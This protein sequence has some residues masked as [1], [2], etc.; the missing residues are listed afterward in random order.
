MNHIKLFEQ[1]INQSEFPA[2]GYDL[3]IKAKNILLKEVD[4]DWLDTN[5]IIKM[6]DGYYYI[7][8]LVHHN[9]FE[10]FDDL[11]DYIFIYWYL[12]EKKDKEVLN[13]IKNTSLDL[14]IDN[15]WY[16]TNSTYYGYTEVVRLILKD[17]RVDPSFDD[18]D[19][20]LLASDNDHPEIVKLLLED[21]RVDPSVYKNSV[22][23]WASKNKHKEIVNLLIRDPRVREKL[24]KKQIE[25]YEGS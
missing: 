20:I 13:V 8:N 10:R 24:T 23:K 5:F 1:H 18:N 2:N 21:P 9:R 7:K 11:K 16:L 14:S 3:P 25:K 17:P 4:R 12:K 6:E 22:I 19:V 15:N